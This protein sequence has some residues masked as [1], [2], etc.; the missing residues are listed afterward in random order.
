M[1]PAVDLF[2]PTPYTPQR[3][4][5]RPKSSPARSALSC[6]PP[7]IVYDTVGGSTGVGSRATAT[8]ADLRLRVAPGTGLRLLAAGE[9]SC[10]RAS[11]RTRLALRGRGA[12]GSKRR[13]SR[14]C[15]CS[16][17]ATRA[18]RCLRPCSPAASAH[19]PPSAAFAPDVLPSSARLSPSSPSGCPPVGRRAD[20]TLAEGV[21]NSRDDTRVV[22]GFGDAAASAWIR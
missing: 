10:R 1:E 14:R 13:R 4:P 8:P 20:S 12:K 2:V 3:R 18:G 17:F 16:R 5:G 11:R 15:P 9:P 21:L 19:G 6:H 22:S 7:R